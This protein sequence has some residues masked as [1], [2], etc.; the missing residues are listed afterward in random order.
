M[1]SAVHSIA[2][3]CHEVNAAYCAALGDKS[4]PTWE[5][6]PEWQKN[7]AIAGVELHLANPDLGVDASHQA[8]MEQKR[9]EGWTYGPVKDSVKKE[10]P[11]YVPYAD[12]PTE[13]KAKDFIFRGVVHAI[14]R[15]MAR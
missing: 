8:W 12:L 11:C 13:Q 14:A 1:K 2:R 4:Q 9:Q 7:S 15:E 6:A 5:D 10:H 3:V